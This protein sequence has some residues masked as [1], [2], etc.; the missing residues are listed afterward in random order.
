MCV[1]AGELGHL[2][3]TE[4]QSRYPS[5]T[6]LN[7]ETKINIKPG[8]ALYNKILQWNFQAFILISSTCWMES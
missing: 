3:L 4:H 6:K 1:N 2:S 5:S 7:L 8:A